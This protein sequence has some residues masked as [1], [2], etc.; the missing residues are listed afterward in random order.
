[1]EL[2]FLLPWCT[3]VGLTRVRSPSALCPFDSVDTGYVFFW[4][5]KATKHCSD[6]TSSGIAT[7]TSGGKIRMDY[8]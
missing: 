1:M 5:F 3:G 4:P 6:D 8:Q 7:I 2:A